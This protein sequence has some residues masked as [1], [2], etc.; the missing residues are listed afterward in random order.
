MVGPP[1]VATLIQ[2]NA[3]STLRSGKFRADPNDPR[4]P[5]R[6][7]AFGYLEG[8]CSARVVSGIGINRSGFGQFL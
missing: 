6:D 4:N 1:F 2:G 5:L 7:N 3:D 8:P